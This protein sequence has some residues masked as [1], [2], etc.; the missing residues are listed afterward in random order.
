MADV[1]SP[2]NNQQVPGAT[3]TVAPTPTPS[4]PSP[5]PA[6]SGMSSTPIFQASP[7]GGV[8][9]TLRPGQTSFE[10]QIRAESDRRSGQASASN[11]ISL[12]GGNASTAI[13][14]AATAPQQGTAKAIDEAPKT[15]EA[16]KSVRNF[17]VGAQRQEKKP[18]D[19]VLWLVVG[20]LLLIAVFIVYFY[21]QQR[22]LKQV[23]PEPTV[24]ESVVLNYWGLWEPNSAFSQV[25]KDFE[26]QNPDVSVIY[27]QKK[28]VDNYLSDLQTALNSSNGPDVFRYHASWRQL[29]A[30][31][32][33]TMPTSLRI[34]SNYDSTFYPIASAQLKNAEGQ[35]Q[36]IPLMYD[37]LALIYNQA[38]FDEA[39]V[40]VPQTWAQFGQTATMLNKYD[41][42][43][44]IV[45]AGAAI[46]LTDN[47]DFASDIIMLMA[48]RQGMDAQDYDED[49]L[50]QA[51][52][53]YTS[54]YTDYNRQVWDRHFDNST[55]AFARGQ[56]AMIIGPSWL[57]HDITKISPSLKI[58]VAPVPQLDLENV[59][60]WATYYAEGV[61]AKAPETRQL[62]AWRLLDYLS[63]PEV[64]R[65]LYESQAETRSFGEIYPRPDMADE[66][67]QNQY[68]APYLQRASRARNLPFNDRTHDHAVNDEANK[69]LFEAI[70]KLIDP[71]AR[72]DNA[73]VRTSILKTLSGYGYAQ[74]PD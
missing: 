34:S 65:Q 69:V 20:G 41:D 12:S 44:Q 14:L 40:N 70:N 23:A 28:D 39:G 22:R 1:N 32:L 38:L 19:W 48:L 74:E 62:A 42:S 9:A 13:K 71:E 4:A 72:G 25:L 15:A 46:G 57:I 29:L 56:V 27:E 17:K 2:I 52:E 35:I 7:S 50:Q 33:S 64:L 8:V 26:D 67:A 59:V 73:S 61:N 58:G 6:T 63:Q 43:D 21:N 37:S 45:Q 53:Y 36:G 24:P 66:L 5:A 16:P 10:G 30:D 18:V 68:I 49:K 47:V 11:T 60:E 55:L 31:Q 54:F 51:M 3:P